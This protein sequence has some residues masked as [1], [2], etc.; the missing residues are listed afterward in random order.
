M[1]YYER[2]NDDDDTV[3]TADFSNALLPTLLNSIT[4]TSQAVNTAL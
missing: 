4:N 3:W 2:I 1:I